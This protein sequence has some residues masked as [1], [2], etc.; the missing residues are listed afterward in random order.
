MVALFGFVGSCLVRLRWKPL[1]AIAGLTI[2]ASALIAAVWIRH[3][4]R[5][6]PA[7]ESYDRSGW[8]LA[9][10]LGAYAAGVLNLIGWMITTPYRWLTRRRVVGQAS[11]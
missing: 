2:I 5:S 10:M 11:A 6:M 9:V 1:I 8:P 7:I 3:D 4:I